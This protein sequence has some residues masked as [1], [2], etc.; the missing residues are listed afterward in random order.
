M[1]RLAF[2]LAAGLAMA[3]AAAHAAGEVK[4][5]ADHFVVDEATHQAVFTGNVIVKHPTLDLWADRVVVHYGEGGTSD[6][7]S[8]EASPQVR[9]K[10]DEQTATGHL[11]T[12]DP[13]SQVMRLTGD[14]TVKNAGTVLHGPEL[15]VNLVTN[16][17]TFTGNSS[18]R[19]TGV[20]KPQ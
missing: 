4:I 13:A 16:T 15:V 6:I 18:G 20:F 19:V 2:V 8:F 14:V 17:S 1:N 3:P 7:E 12:Y 5:T 10:T 11:A 9:I